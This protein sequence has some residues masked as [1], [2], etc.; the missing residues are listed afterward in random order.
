VIARIESNHLFNLILVATLLSLGQVPAVARSGDREAS[1]LL[2]MVRSSKPARDRA[3]SVREVEI[4]MGPASLVIGEGILLPAEAVEGRSLEIAFVGDAWF[5]FATSDPV[6]SRQLELFTGDLALLT[7]V[8]HAVLVTGN[9]SLFKSVLGGEP[10]AG[11]PVREALEVFKDWVKGPERQGFAADLAM[12]KTLLGEPLYRD[13]F[14]VWCRSP[15]LGDFYYIIDP[16]EA[17]PVVLGQFVPVDLSGLDVWERRRAKNYMRRHKLFG[18]FAEFSIEHPGQWDTW[19]ST[20]LRAPDTAQTR[21]SSE[22]EPEHYTLDM[23]VNPKIELDAKASA[24]VRLRAGPT[25]AYSVEFSLYPG[26][27]VTRVFGPDEEPLEFIRREGAL[28]VFLAEP[29]APGAAFDVRVDYEGDLVE[30]LPGDESYALLNTQAWYPRTGQIDRATYVATLRRPRRYAVLASGQITGSGVDDGVAWERR[31]L[32]LPALG[33]TFEL[34]RFDI[35]RDRVGHVDLTFG[36]PEENSGSEGAVQETIIE[37]VKRCLPALEGK[38]GPYPLDYLTV[39]TVNRSFSQGMLSMVSL[40]D[41]A[42]GDLSSEF[43]EALQEWATERRM[44]TIAHEISH[45]W[46]GNWVGWSSYRD[47]W[48]SEALASYSALQFGVET[49]ES[50]SAFMVR[51]ARDWRSSLTATTQEGRTVG[52][53]G[54][55][56]LGRRLSS[57]KSSRGYEAI[58]YDKGAAVLRMLSGMIGEEPFEQM[59][60][61][62]TK[63]VANR[64]LDTVTFLKALERMSELDLQPFAEQFVFGTGIPEVYYRY[65]IEPGEGGKDWLIR[66]EAR[67]LSSGHENL[68]ITRDHS[69]GWR[70]EQEMVIH[71]D[72][73]SSTLVVPFQVVITPPEQV[74]TGDWGKIQSA[75]GFGGRLVLKGQSTPFLLK[76]P[77]KP[78]KLELDQF[79]EVLALFHDEDWTP[80]RTLRV[81]AQDL[82]TRGDSRA[83]EGMLRQALEAPVYSERAVAWMSPKR[84]KSL[85]QDA[86]AR[87]EDARIHTLLAGLLMDLGDLDGSEREIVAA[88]ALLEEPD[89][90][91]GWRDRHLLRSRLD[92]AKGDADAAYQ[93]LKKGLR[94]GW[95][96]A[97]GYALLALAANETGRDRVADQAMRRAEARGVDVRALREARSA[98][99]GKQA[100]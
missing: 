13:Y 24:N 19:V 5:R 4:D 41:S 18:R 73:S 2:E 3:V 62:L 50:K 29:A 21:G 16:S 82:A 85:D 22:P 75:R 67:Q 72:V 31:S 43:P 96:D 9:E 1:R 54:P 69:G 34:G 81:Q 25:A 15:E 65:A 52:S 6:E 95:L 37:T 44:L 91:A 78:E 12:G 89:K 8:S 83:A 10:A 30:S 17:E 87:V 47:Q 27:R 77:E 46:W 79:G 28:H 66:G 84:R 92:L 56:T 93:R 32:D 98:S 63:A 55:V 7:P 68:A 36:F 90:E 60:G 64:T 97:E 20:R 33:F 49:A 86:E 100:S 11:A 40:A 76:V 57:S 59:L 23:Y 38:L 14:A 48:L 80:K 51:N 70:V 61:A 99:S 88:E 71:D 35:V 58:V 94:R 74:D 26:L 42:M 39:V 53:L 45:Q